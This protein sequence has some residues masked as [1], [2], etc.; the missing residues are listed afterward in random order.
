MDRSQIIT[1]VINAVVTIVTTIVV[2][3]LSL[4]KG[5]LGIASKLKA[6]F[7]PKFR[8][9]IA[10]IFC[11]LLFIYIVSDMYL[12]ISEPDA[13][14]VNRRHVLR[15]IVGAAGIAI[16]LMLV[17]KALGNLITVTRDE[18]A[19]EELERWRPVIEAADST[20]RTI[21]ASKDDA[22]SPA[23]SSPDRQK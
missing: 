2:T 12:F 16:W 20:R 19:R 13:P 23:D 22:E 11:L 8:A 4:N 14:P 6:R 21:E 18:K 3:R 15:I 9:Y 17:F 5:E 10:L 1:L 7:T